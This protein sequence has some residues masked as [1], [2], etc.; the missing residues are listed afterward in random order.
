[1]LLCVNGRKNDEVSGGGRKFS[2]EDLRNFY[3]L[4]GYIK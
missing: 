3:A 4:P 2:D 1:M